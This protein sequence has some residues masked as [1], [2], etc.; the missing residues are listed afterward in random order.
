MTTGYYWQT[1]GMFLLE[2]LCV[3]IIL[4]AVFFACGFAAVRMPV[5]TIVLGPIALAVLA[6][7]IHVRA[8]ICVR[9]T[10]GLLPRAN[11]PSGAAAA[12]A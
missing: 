7:L 9:W 6:W 12:T 8:L 5:L 4:Y 1:F 11:A 10:L 2:G 3:A